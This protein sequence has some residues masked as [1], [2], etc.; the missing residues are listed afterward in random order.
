MDIIEDRTPS[1]VKKQTDD[2]WSIVTHNLSDQPV[3]D[4]Y[5]AN[6]TD[7]DRYFGEQQAL[8]YQENGTL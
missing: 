4:Q 5:I 6:E 7:A 8:L 2:G 3:Q 1:V